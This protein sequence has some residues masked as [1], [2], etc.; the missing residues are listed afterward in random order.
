[1][2]RKNCKKH[3]AYELL[4]VLGMSALVLF[5]CRLWPLLILALLGMLGAAAG[6]IL[7][8]RK[9]EEPEKPRA[10]LPSH[11]QNEALGR[12][13]SQISALV[14]AEHLN[15]RWDMEDAEC[16]IAGVLRRG[17]INSAQPRRRL[18]RGRR[19]H[20]RWRGGES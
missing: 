3:V 4:V 5:V 15:A 16:Q 2:N 18:P 7:A 12:I 20:E 11:E 1:M 17:R 8:N 19:A 9:A 10:L 13:Q 14:R 6:L